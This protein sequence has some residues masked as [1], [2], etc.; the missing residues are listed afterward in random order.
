[1]SYNLNILYYHIYLLYRYFNVLCRPDN[2]ILKK[3][4]DFYV[5]TAS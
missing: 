2:N 4:I 3:E 1:M 5:Y